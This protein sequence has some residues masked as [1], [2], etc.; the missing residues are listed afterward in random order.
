MEWQE[1]DELRDSDDESDDETMMSSLSSLKVRHPTLTL[2]CQ[3]IQD[4]LIIWV[5]GVACLHPVHHNDLDWPQ[6]GRQACS[7][8]PQMIPAND[9]Q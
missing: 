2:V 4:V 6:D 5:N 9:W 3:I 7:L 8:G 1:A